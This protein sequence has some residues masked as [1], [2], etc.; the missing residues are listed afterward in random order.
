MKGLEA[1]PVAVKEKEY[2][3]TLKSLKVCHVEEGKCSFSVYPEDRTKF[4]KLKL[5]RRRILTVRATCH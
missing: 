3:I 5:L 1:E 4:N 2:N